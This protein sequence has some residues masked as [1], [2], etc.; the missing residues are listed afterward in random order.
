MFIKLK[1]ILTTK[2][3]FTKT[4]E[5]LKVTMIASITVF[6]ILLTID[7][8]FTD[9][10]DDDLELAT[11]IGEMVVSHLDENYITPEVISDEGCNVFG[12]ELHGELLTYISN[13]NLSED[14]YP[15]LDQ[16]SSE[17]IIIDINNSNKDSKIKA[18]LLEV[19]SFGGSPTAAEEIDAAIK[20][21]EKP[22]IAY[23]RTL[24]LSAA[25]WAISGARYIVALPSSD[26]GSIGATMSYVDNSKKNIQEG[27]T[28]NQLST[29]KYKDTLNS[30]KI[31]TFEEKQLIMRD[32]NIIKDNFIKAVSENRK[33]EIEKV[34][35]LADGSSMPGQMA[36]DKKMV[37]KLGTFYDVKD[38]IKGI[39]GEN[40]EICW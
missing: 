39:I 26:V 12:I 3:N 38:Y 2:L 28:F 1:N 32:L 13:E 21:S 19:D 17:E 29:G 33:I 35:V 20:H 24:G 4:K 8:I 6:T 30:D 23:I 9:F 27:L 7:L 34:K 16:S 11:E 18:I 36:L 40:V 5:F 15:L 37:D 22:V 10:I 14:A 25:Y 31:L